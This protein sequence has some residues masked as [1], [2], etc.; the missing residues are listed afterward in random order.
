M[1]RAEATSTWIT[2]SMSGFFYVNKGG[3]DTG[4]STSGID[5]GPLSGERAIWWYDQTDLPFYYQL[6][7]TF[8]L[9][10]HYH[11][12][13]PG[14]TWPNRMYLYAATSF[15]ET[16]NVF[17]DLTAYPFPSNDATI[18]DELEKRHVTWL[19]YSDGAPGAGIVLRDGGGP[20]L[21]AD[22]PRQL[23]A[24]PEGRGGGQPAA[25]SFVDPNLDSETR[26]RGTDEHPPGD[27][28]SGEHFVGQVVQAVT[29]SPQWAA[30]SLFITHDENGGFYD[31]VPPAAACAPDDIA[32]ILTGATTRA[33][34]LR[35][36][37]FRVPF[38]ACQPYSKKAY[39]AHTVYDTRASRASSRRS[40]RSRRSPRATR[41]PTR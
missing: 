38:I 8:A 27:I 18:L 22:H 16:T 4:D 39:V 9:A 5:A 24:V 23:R 35:Q 14:P 7:S 25:V 19:R 31:H 11:C 33:G 15:G 28:Q 13:V 12:S 26:R 34:G 41:T 10:D 20:P 29:T 32:P 1:P 17:P 2:A 6:A 21:G 3:Q 40:S 30:P 36:Y 37:G